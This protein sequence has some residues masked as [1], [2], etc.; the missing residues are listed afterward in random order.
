MLAISIDKGA[1]A[2]A[3]TIEIV[4]A[5]GAGLRHRGKTIRTGGL[6]KQKKG[7]NTIQP[8]RFGVYFAAARS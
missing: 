7:G 8:A 6:K 4:G 2:G 3:D 5:G 1:M